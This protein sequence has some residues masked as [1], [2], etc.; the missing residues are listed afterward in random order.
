[1][2]T[3]L[4]REEHESSIHL[5]HLYDYVSAWQISKEEVKDLAMMLEAALEEARETTQTQIVD[6]DGECCFHVTPGGYIILMLPWKKYKVKC[7]E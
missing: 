6:K 3:H 1:M 2:I 5:S 4:T 7:S